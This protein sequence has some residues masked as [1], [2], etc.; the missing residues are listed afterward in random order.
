MIDNSIPTVHLAK[1]EQKRSLNVTFSVDNF[2]TLNQY[3]GILPSEGIPTLAP[4]N[5]NIKLYPNLKYLGIGIYPISEDTGNEPPRHRS[6][7]GR[8]FRPIPWTFRAIGSDLNNLEKEQYRLRI[9]VPA[10]DPPV[11]LPNTSAGLLPDVE[12]KPGYIYYFLKV[13]DLDAIAP[14][15][16]NVIVSDGVVSGSGQIDLVEDDLQDIAPVDI[17]NATLY[18][19]TGEHR[20]V[21]TAINLSLDNTDIT[22]LVA[23]V[24][25]LFNSSAGASITELAIVSGYDKTGVSNMP[26][27]ITH[28]QVANFIGTNIPLQGLPSAVN[29]TFALSTSMPH[30]NTI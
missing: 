1:L 14:T 8:L 23:T 6:T 12:L 5:D 26:L 7:D 17:D 2:S 29:H 24:T 22:N 21:Q 13:L 15:L 4:P 25:H 20:V 10:L 11:I 30:P 18:N 16:Y 9:E 27:E 28:A 3:F 19:V